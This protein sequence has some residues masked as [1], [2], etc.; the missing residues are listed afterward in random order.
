M[1]KELVKDISIDVLLQ[2]VEDWRTLMRIER[3][4]ELKLDDAPKRPLRVEQQASFKELRS[5]FC[6]DYCETLCD[7]VG[8]NHLRVLAKLEGELALQREEYHPKTA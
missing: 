4:R 2:A 5:F 1:T 8:L 6:S 3:S 7:L